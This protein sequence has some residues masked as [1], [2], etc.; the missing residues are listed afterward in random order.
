MSA[1]EVAT[2]EATPV[3]VSPRAAEKIASILSSEADAAMLRG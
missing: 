3:T 2:T 1:T